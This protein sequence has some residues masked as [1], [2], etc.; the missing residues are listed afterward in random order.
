M[1]LIIDVEATC[2]NDGAITPPNMEIIE[3]G[4]CWAMADGS[5]VDR[6]QSFVRPIERPILTEFCTQ[7]TGIQQSEIDTA[8]AF[9]EASKALRAFVDRH[10]QSDSLWLS[11]GA[12]DRKQFDLEINRHGVPTPLPLPHLNAKKQ[13]AKLQKIGKEVGMARALTICRLDMEGSHHRAL[14]DAMNI[15]RLLPWILGDRLQHEERKPTWHPY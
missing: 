7:L 9:P 11:W 2:S 13:F 4:A 12:Y 1:Y 3:I 10:I 14:D 5:V 6:F 8:P 15:A